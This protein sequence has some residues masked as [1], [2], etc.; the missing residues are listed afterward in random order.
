[1][2]AE[3]R[4]LGGR[5]LTPFFLGLLGLFGIAAILITYRVFAGVGSITALT[6]G[7]SWGIWKPINVVSFTG[8]GAGAYG[9]GLL[10]YVLNHGKYHPLVRPAVLV[11]ALA[12]SLGGGSVMVDLG[13][14]WNSVFLAWLP[15]YNLNSI[16]LEVAVCVI[17]YC[18]V[19]WVEVLPSL[20]EKWADEGSP[21]QKAFAARWIPPLRNALPFI[22]ALA[23]LLPTMHQSSLGSLYL[24][25][26]TKVHPLWYTG[27]LPFLFLVSCLTMGYGA[28]V[29]MDVLLGVVF[30][31]RYRTH[32][33]LLGSLAKVAAG[34]SLFY[35]AW[36]FAMLAVEGRLSYAFGAAWTGP[37]G[38]L[39]TFQIPFFWLEIALFLVSAVMYLTPSVR[40]N[41]GR[42]LLAGFV[43][44]LAGAAY[45]IN[46]Y[47]T[48]YDPGPGWHYFPSVGETMVTVG[49]AAVGLSVF[50]LVVK[51]LPILALGYQGSKH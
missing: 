4:P 27:W 46:T 16:L 25:A 31:G 6:D 3:A 30:R 38:R 49:L 35:V 11:G 51:K 12:Y 44:V 14:W 23:L 45:R 36:R 7:Y 34:L 13:R 20:L 48:A 43:G 40:E 9:V 19:L 15:W 37:G 41:R 5:I 42:L 1:M 47:L 2:S 26:P 32:M 50:I 28:V 29:G 18:G 21:G 10:C 22:I 8:I 17:A 24:M 33:K 39:Q